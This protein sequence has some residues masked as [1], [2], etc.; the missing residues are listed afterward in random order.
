VVLKRIVLRLPDLKSIM[1]YIG[2]SLTA[3]AIFLLWLVN[4]ILGLAF[5]AFV[6]VVFIWYLKTKEKGDVY[7]K[8]IAKRTGCQFVSGGPGYGSVSGSYKGHQIEVKITKDYDL[9]RG[10][11]G[12]AISTV[13][14]NSLLGTLAG[15][16]NFAIVRVKHRGEI[17][18][19]YR[20]DKQTYVDKSFIITLLPS[21]E[22][23][24]IPKIG[25]D[26]L[27]SKIDELIAKAE[28]IERRSKRSLSWL[29]T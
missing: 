2:F 4:W 6:V 13:I 28:E 26:S 21:D 16:K 19:P 7:L 24:G 22:V 5:T 12:M 11:T 17:D 20:L 1:S 14:L 9:S 18:K 23:T 25:I 8:A 10:I 3:I 27:I 29:E 15:I